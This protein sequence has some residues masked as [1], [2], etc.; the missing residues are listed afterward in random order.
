[1]D[2]DLRNLLIVSGIAIAVLFIARP[3]GFFKRAQKKNIEIPSSASKEDREFENGAEA[4]SAM[5]SAANSGE[6]NEF[7]DEMNQYFQDEYGL[8]VHY[9]NGLFHAKN[10]AGK[11]VAK[12]K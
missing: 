4:I 7:L 10:K 12:E 1:M 3:K 6:S 2:K 8:K 11:I 5:R 9:E